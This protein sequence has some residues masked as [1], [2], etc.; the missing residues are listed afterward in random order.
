[1]ISS[2]SL[3]VDPRCAIL[4]LAAY[5]AALSSL[6]PGQN[7]GLAILSSLPFLTLAF[8]PANR[9]ELLAQAA[10]VLPFSFAIAAV[11]LLR[12]NTAA[13]IFFLLR[14][15]VSILAVLLVTRLLTPLELLRGLERLGAP[16]FLILVTEFLM[17]YLDVL[18]KEA[19]AMRLAKLCR[20]GAHN[21]L[22]AASTLGMLFVRSLERSASIH[23]CMLARGF[24][25]HLP[26]P[27]PLHW[28]WA[29][30]AVLATGLAAIS[31]LRLAL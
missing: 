17:R 18:R 26:R 19:D 12:G 23:N 9:S 15:Y 13:A 24:N 10:C 27:F 3:P 14:S 16:R 5:L 20:G 2:K 31:V 30:S 7:L 22:L 25:G 4:L 1:M 11:A 21:Q 6:T 29:D 28:R 8:S